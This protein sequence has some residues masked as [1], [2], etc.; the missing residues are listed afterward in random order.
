MGIVHIHVFG[1]N[2]EIVGG[3]DSLVV[4]LVSIGYWEIVVDIGVGNFGFVVGG[5]G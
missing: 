5:N 2:L 4:G 3:L 1:S